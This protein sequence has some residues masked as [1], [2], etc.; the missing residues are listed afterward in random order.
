MSQSPVLSIS[1]FPRAFVSPVFPQKGTRSRGGESRSFI[2]PQTGCGHKHTGNPLMASVL[3]TIM[4]A[5]R[6]QKPGGRGAE[7][8]WGTVGPGADGWERPADWGLEPQGHP[9]RVCGS[10]ERSVLRSPQEGGWE[11]EGRGSSG[12]SPPPSSRCPGYPRE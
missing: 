9:C 11:S 8:G 12:Q 5:S 3:C 4:S 6:K 2:P 7:G 1:M 10:W